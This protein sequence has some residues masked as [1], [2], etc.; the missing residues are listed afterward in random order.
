M[1]QSNFS[2]VYQS[3]AAATN[4]PTNNT[5]HLQSIILE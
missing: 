2:I 4:N 3:I 1:K 5:H